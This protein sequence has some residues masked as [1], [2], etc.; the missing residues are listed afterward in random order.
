V[1][2]GIQNV[3]GRLTLE[4]PGPFYDQ[5]GSPRV[6]QVSGHKFP[7][8]LARRPSSNHRPVNLLLVADQ[9]VFTELTLPDAPLVAVTVP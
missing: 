4:P 9:S 8:P 7:I 5:G 2:S 3:R 1:D 6:Y